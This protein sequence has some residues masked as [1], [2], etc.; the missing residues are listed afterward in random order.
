MILIL[1]ILFLL[2]ILTIINRLIF[3]AI[4]IEESDSYVSLRDYLKMI[5]MF[6]VWPLNKF[7][8]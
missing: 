6:W 8:K 3:V 2:S 4:Y 5:L 7:D 1:T